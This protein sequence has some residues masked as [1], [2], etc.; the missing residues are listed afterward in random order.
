MKKTT[1][2]ILNLLLFLFTGNLFSQNDY[3]SLKVEIVNLK[4]SKGNI[5][6]QLADIKGNI[7]KG[8]V[9][10]VINNRC[11]ILIDSLVYGIY[12]IRYFHDENS[13]NNL[14]VNWFGLPSEGYGFSNNASAIFGTPPI[15][16]RE[17]ELK[18]NLEMKLSPK[19]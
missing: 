1:I 14:D 4:N 11:E 2:I 9:S 3:C 8:I 18:E 13:N 15:Q 10:N 7:V 19:Y 16:D 17:F 6:L 12:T 5:D